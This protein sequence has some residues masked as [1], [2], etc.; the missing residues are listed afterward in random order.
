MAFVQV[1]GDSLYIGKALLSGKSLVVLWPGQGK[2]PVPDSSAASSK[3]MASIQP[4]WGNSAFSVGTAPSARRRNFG[5]PMIWTH[6]GLR[7][8]VEGGE[9]ALR[10]GCSHSYRGHNCPCFPPLP[11]PPL[12]PSTPSEA[13]QHH[14]PL[15]GVRVGTSSL[16][17]LA[18]PSLPFPSATHTLF[19]TGPRSCG[20]ENRALGLL[21]WPSGWNAHS[22]Q[23][24]D[25]GCFSQ[26]LA[27]ELFGSL[28]PV[29]NSV[30]F[31]TWLKIKQEIIVW[32]TKEICSPFSR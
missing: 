5:C 25:E 13:A 6:A 16:G 14:L 29:L 21:P 31:Q 3:W 12:S 2:S 30:K 28:F 15:P 27:L 24:V 4:R 10:K 22:H 18:Q 32:K 19:N 26:Q 17:Q 9:W 23:T 7:S 1:H 8:K 20:W 11:L